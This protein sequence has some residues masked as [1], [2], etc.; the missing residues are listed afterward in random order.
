MYGIT[1]V[2]KGIS[3]NHAGPSHFMT[4]VTCA[5][6]EA[7]GK[8]GCVGRILV[9]GRVRLPSNQTSEGHHDGSGCWFRVLGSKLVNVGSSRCW[10]SSRKGCKPM[11]QLAS[12]FTCVSIH[13]GSALAVFYAN[14]K[15]PKWDKVYT[16]FSCFPKHAFPKSEYAWCTSA[17]NRKNDH[18]KWLRVWQNKQINYYFCELASPMV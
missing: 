18:L 9:L 14:K 3:T 6:H 15:S 11:R 16:F 7:T 13:L 8:M 1:N 4:P 17:S 5:I 2:K 12:C 10:K